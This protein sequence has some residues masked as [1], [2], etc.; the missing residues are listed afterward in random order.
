MIIRLG[1]SQMKSKVKKWCFDSPKYLCEGREL[2]LN[3]FK[4]GL[5]PLK[6][7]KGTGFKILPPK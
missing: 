1:Q 5:F 7:T 3:A 2:V 6:L 4:S